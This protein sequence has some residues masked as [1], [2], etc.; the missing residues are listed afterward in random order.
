MHEGAEAAAAQISTSEH[1]H[2]EWSVTKCARV[3]LLALLF[4]YGAVS[5]VEPCFF[6]R[7]RFLILGQKCSLVLE[8]DGAAS[9]MSFMIVD[10][11]HCT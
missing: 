2:Y 3:C 4:R 1:H 7:R 8:L 5:L 11:C 10:E 6:C 9:S